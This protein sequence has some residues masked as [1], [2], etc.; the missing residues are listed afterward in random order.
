MMDLCLFTGYHT[1][2]PKVLSVSAQAALC[3]PPLGVIEQ[4]VCE[5][6]SIR[7]ISTIEI[8]ICWEQVGNH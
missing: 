5:L 4:T 2:F 1:A 8:T 6:L 7:L 3:A